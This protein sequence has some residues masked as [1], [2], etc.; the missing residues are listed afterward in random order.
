M[1]DDASESAKRPHRL[2]VFPLKSPNEL[3]R[4]AVEDID[5]KEDKG[6]T[7]DQ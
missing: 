3:D 2:K 6:I 7:N 4:L 1:E 5:S